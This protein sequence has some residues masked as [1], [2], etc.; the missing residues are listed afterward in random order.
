L[1]Q[2]NVEITYTPTDSLRLSL[3]VDNLFNE[4][5]DKVPQAIWDYNE[6]RYANTNRQYLTGSPVGY[7]GARWF[8]KMAFNF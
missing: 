5:P 4:Y 2:T 7:F 6:E 8:A 3:G 1:M